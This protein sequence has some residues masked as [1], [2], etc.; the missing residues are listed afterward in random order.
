MNNSEAY[1]FAHECSFKDGNIQYADIIFK[2]ME[3]IRKY[4]KY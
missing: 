2:M 4:I 1:K 3:F